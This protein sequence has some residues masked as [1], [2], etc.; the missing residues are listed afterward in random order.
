MTMASRAPRQY[1]RKS[2]IKRAILAARD[3]GIDVAGFEVFP[4][5]RIVIVE[6]RANPVQAMDEFERLCAEGRL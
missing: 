6:A 2:E 3:C 1:P 5:G 4:D